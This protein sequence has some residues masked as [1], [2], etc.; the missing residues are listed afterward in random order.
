MSLD[1][2]DS[3]LKQSCESFDAL[4]GDAG[5]ILIA[6]HFFEKQLRHIGKCREIKAIQRSAETQQ[7]FM[8]EM[9]CI[10]EFAGTMRFIILE[11]RSFNKAA[12]PG[13][14]IEDRCHGEPLAGI[15]VHMMPWFC[16]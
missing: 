15:C 7:I 6:N 9:P 8:T 11:F 10:Q 14:G 5:L 4:V 2:D 12:K 1:A 16:R 13:A 3:S